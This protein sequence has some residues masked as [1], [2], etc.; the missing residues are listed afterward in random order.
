MINIDQLAQYLIHKKTMCN[1]VLTNGKRFKVIFV[2]NNKNSVEYKRPI[3]IHNDNKRRFDDF[4]KGSYIYWCIEKSEIKSI[5]QYI[6]I[7][8]KKLS[9]VQPVQP[10]QNDKQNNFNF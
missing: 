3:T 9:P 7:K 2:T 1:V 4:P 5:D 6:F 10:V 8:N